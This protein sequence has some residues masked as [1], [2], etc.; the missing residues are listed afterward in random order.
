[1]T[2]EQEKR[3]S[4]EELFKY[5]DELK[6]DMSPEDLKSIINQFKDPINKLIVEKILLEKNK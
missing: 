4:I 5:I 2:L 3:L 6:K 1:M